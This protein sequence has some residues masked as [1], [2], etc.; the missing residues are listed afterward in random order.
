MSQQSDAPACVV[1]PEEDAISN[2]CAP[3]LGASCRIKSSPTEAGSST[4]TM[5]SSTLSLHSVCTQPVPPC[6]TGPFQ[7]T[8]EQPALPVKAQILTRAVEN[9]ATRLVCSTP[10]ALVRC[11]V[12]INWDYSEPGTPPDPVVGSHCLFV[13]QTL[14]QKNMLVSVYGWA[15]TVGCN[16][17]YI[18]LQNRTSTNSATERYKVQV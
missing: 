4:C 6:G 7:Q 15:D 3:F 11:S 8:C 12:Y 9:C 16:E 17:A 14:L 13:L 18:L 2:S 5:H 10:D 1:F